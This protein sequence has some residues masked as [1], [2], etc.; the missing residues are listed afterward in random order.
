[1]AKLDQNTFSIFKEKIDLYVFLQTIYEKV[2][3]AFQNK[4]MKLMIDCP[5]NLWINLDP[6]RF[7]QVIINL[8]DNSL[9][10]SKEMTT[11]LVRVNKEKDEIEITIKDQGIGIPQEDL[12][13]I[14]DRLYRVEKSRSR[15]TGGFGLGLAIVKQIVEAH[16]G[17]ISVESQVGHGTCFIINLKQ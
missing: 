1:M 13:Y 3:P 8:L 5:K 15:A 2:L 10:Y 9:K 14:F 6:V 11:T 17:E 4:K 16:G 12:P 7:E